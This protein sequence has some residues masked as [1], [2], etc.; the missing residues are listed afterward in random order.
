MD[1][2]GEATQ[3]WTQSDGLGTMDSS[4]VKLSSMDWFEGTI[5]GNRG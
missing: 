1:I 3:F 5:R 2:W 4:P